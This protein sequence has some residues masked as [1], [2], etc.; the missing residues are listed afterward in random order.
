[1]FQVTVSTSPSRAGRPAVGW[2]ER[3]TTVLTA[4]SVMNVGI[5]AARS[6][7]GLASST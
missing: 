4:A 6:I 5:T 2:V 3:F 1:M 7:S